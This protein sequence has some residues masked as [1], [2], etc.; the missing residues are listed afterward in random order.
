M[1]F[2]WRHDAASRINLD[3]KEG[4]M[5]RLY[6]VPTLV[7]NVTIILIPALLTISL[8]FFRWDGISQ[9]TFIGFANFQALWDDRIFW[10]ALGNN[11][12]WTALFLTVPIAMGLLAATL[13]L[14][15]K[16]G[17]MF[18]QVIY[19][20]PMII[21]TV[22]LARIWQGMIFSPVTGVNGMLQRLGFPTIDPLSST[23]T[24][25]FAIATVDLWHWWGFLC[26]IFFA[27][28]R[29][30]PSEQVEAARIEGASFWQL[31]RYVLLPAIRPTITLMM[32]MTVIWSF[33]VFDFVYVLTQGGPAFSSEVL[34]TLAYR[35]AFYDL[36]VGKAAAV[37]VVISLFGLAATTFYIRE[38]S[39][40]MS[41]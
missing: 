39:K 27:A 13:L 6:L 30:V 14:V 24:S 9:P 12:K 17:S 23:A 2:G 28:L 1:P 31:L 33:L 16:R 8:A 3:V 40:E 37:A 34:S 41:R 19:F 32:I 21:A 25:L 4:L 15:A 29:Q 7:I 11:I 20:L 35:N 18:F 10:R 38:Q 5:H 36:A 22:I 26:V